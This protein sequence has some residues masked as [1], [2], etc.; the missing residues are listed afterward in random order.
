MVSE[1]GYL[2]NWLY[3]ESSSLLLHFESIEGPF[4]KKSIYKASDGDFCKNYHI[5]E[6]CILHFL[7]FFRSRLCKI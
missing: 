4:V 5:Q 2:N 7:H 3:G 6:F 1:G